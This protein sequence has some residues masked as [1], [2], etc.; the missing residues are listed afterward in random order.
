MA[1]PNY[2][3]LKLRMSGPRRIITIGASFQR[4]DECEVECCVLAAVTIASEVLA[5]IRKDTIEEAPDSKRS[6]R[7]FE[8]TEGTKE[9]LIDP[10]SSDGKLLRVGTDL[11][12]K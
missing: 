2:T 5:I 10:S 4:A 1:I 3:Y 8:P 6:A 9:V 7:S 12:T 11:S